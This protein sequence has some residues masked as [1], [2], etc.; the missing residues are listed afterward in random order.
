MSVAC[1]PAGVATTVR[2]RIAL[3]LFLAL[4]YAT[5]VFLVPHNSPRIQGMDTDAIMAY[6]HGAYTLGNGERL[7][8]DIEPFKIQGAGYPL[9]LMIA[10]SLF[11]LSQNVEVNYGLK[12]F[13]GWEYFRAGKWISVICAMS[14]IIL[15]V[16]WL[17]LWPGFIASVAL[18]VSYLFFQLSYSG[19]TDIFAVA[20]LFWTAYLLYRQKSLLA[21]IL[22]GLALITRYEYVLFLPFGLWYLHSKFKDKRRLENIKL[23][24]FLI[25]VFVFVYINF[26]IAPFPPDGGR[27]NLALHYLNDQNQPDAFT[28]SILAD[29]PTVFHIIFN[30]IGYTTKIFLR[31]LWNTVADIGVRQV[32]SVLF[33]F[34]ILILITRWQYDHEF[35]LVTVA[36]T[37]HFFVIVFLMFSWE[38]TRYFMPEIIALT[39]IGA[40]S[41]EKF[42]SRKLSLALIPLIIFNIGLLTNE[43]D[44]TQ[45]R[46]S[47]DK[48]GH[49]RTLIKPDE[50]VLSLRPML[51][52][53]NGIGWRYWNTEIKPWGLYR[54]CID[55]G[56][57]YVHYGGFESYNRKEFRGMFLSY[58]SMVPEFLPVDYKPEL[59]VLA[60]VNDAD[61]VRVKN[62]LPKKPI[63]EYI[64]PV[65][66]IFED[67]EYGEKQ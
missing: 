5:F 62:G 64:E 20:L 56:I 14:I 19:T 27:Y 22:F 35:R 50:E 39:F 44:A 7:W 26:S 48:Y 17:G 36:L 6:V 37:L 57:E 51:A 55:E 40:W 43:T 31:D 58:D 41:M 25:P 23:L 67:M 59:G 28:Q 30:D 42:C 12:L 18:G 61:S 63:E 32:W 13:P 2:D 53:V 9:T 16:V 15:A 38:T 8:K 65:K 1:C 10:G 21:G 3:G 34:A 4:I 29:N 47:L 49:Y 60:R 54:Y 24:A 33:F 46:D 66:S 11:Q 45:R 52:F